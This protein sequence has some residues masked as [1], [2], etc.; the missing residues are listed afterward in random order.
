MHFEKPSVPVHK[1]DTH[2]EESQPYG[3][4][5]R[6]WHVVRWLRHT[7]QFGPIGQRHI[8][9]ESIIPAAHTQCVVTVVSIVHHCV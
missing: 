3:E 6:Q 7:S 1:D 5:V 2:D 4:E 9:C 8:W